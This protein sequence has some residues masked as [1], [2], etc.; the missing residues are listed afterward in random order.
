MAGRD[1]HPR[2]QL[3]RDRWR[4]LDG[5]WQFAY[6]DADLG[7]AQHWAEREEPFERTIR[8]PFPPESSASG[9]GDAAPHPVLWYRRVIHVTAE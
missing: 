5:D 7:L 3:T 2:P 4:S 1:E 9:I 8:V 6:D